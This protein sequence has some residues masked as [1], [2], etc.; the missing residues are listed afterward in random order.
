[1]LHLYIKIYIYI[2]TT[3]RT[4]DLLC[5]VVNRSRSQCNPGPRSRFPPSFQPS[6][7]HHPWP[8]VRFDTHKTAKVQ[9][10]RHQHGLCPDLAGPQ[11]SNARLLNCSW[12][13]STLQA[14]VAASSNY[15]ASTRKRLLLGC[16]GVFLSTLPPRF[17]HFPRRGM[18]T[19]SQDWRERSSASRWHCAVFHHKLRNLGVS[20]SRTP[21]DGGDADGVHSEPHPAS[22]EKTC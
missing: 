4:L 13:A 11:M 22:Y 9:L 3:L 18:S 19:K 2:F 17:P 15:N 20:P 1:M 16:S 8:I 21:V 10:I 14:A 6:K 5:I 7:H 12:K